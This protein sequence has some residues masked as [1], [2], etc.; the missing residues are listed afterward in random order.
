MSTRESNKFYLQIVSVLIS[1]ST[2]KREKTYALLDTESQCTLI[3][4][5]FAKSSDMETQATWKEN[6]N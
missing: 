5:Y 2:G 3:R 1:S 4:Q 6:Q